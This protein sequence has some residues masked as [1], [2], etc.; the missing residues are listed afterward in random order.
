VRIL[1]IDMPFNSGCIKGFFGR[2]DDSS[3]GKIFRLGIIWCRL[4]EITAE[5]AEAQF[6]D[7]G[8]S[9]DSEDLAL[10]QKNQIAGSKSL[11]ETH[12]KLIAAQKV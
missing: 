8:D 6:T 2:S 4:P 3:D 11:Q 9:V 12:Q 7:T 10:L 5:E 1:Y